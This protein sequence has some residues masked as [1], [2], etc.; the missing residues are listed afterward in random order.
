MTEVRTEL[1]FEDFTAGRVFDLG[2]IDLDRDEMVT[3]ASRY[4]P[5]PTY[6][7]DAAA[8]RNPLVGKLCASGLFVAALWSRAFAEQVLNRS[9]ALSSPGAN[10]ISWPAPV[11]A[12][13]QLAIR[14]GVL[15]SRLS[16][17]Q[18]GVGLV[19]V[20]ATSHR[21]DQCVYRA[22]FALLLATR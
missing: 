5:Q 19:D 9:T 15:S 20:L 21:D 4:D 17:G 11:F 14:G 13:D 8:A 10:N 22:Q 2:T 12:G 18:P 16:K 6:L 1:A 7:D 3:F